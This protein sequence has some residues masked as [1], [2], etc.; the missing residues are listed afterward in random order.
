MKHV[1]VTGA[2]GGIGSA[3]VDELLAGG[4][5]V[6]AIDLSTDALDRLPHHARL[7][8]VA[9]DVTDSGE[10]AHAVAAGIEHHGAPYGLLNIAGNNR[11][12]PLEDITDQD[13]H[14]LI[15]ANLTSTFLMC[16]EVMPHM[17]PAGGRVVN[18]ASIF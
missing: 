17:R 15:D 10:V 14:F 9:A 7:L 18:T 13:W 16:R 11:L 1:I 3:A 6:T 5:A 12:G 2:A 4:F 8:P